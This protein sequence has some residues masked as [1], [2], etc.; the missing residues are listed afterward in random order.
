MNIIIFCAVAYGIYKLIS[1]FAHR[2]E[3]I[4]AEQAAQHEA[5]R[6][7]DRMIIDQARKA[8]EHDR[9]IAVLAKEQQKQAEQIARIQYQLNTATA[10]ID[11]LQSHIAELD[12]QLDYYLLQQSGAVPGSKS[13]ETYQNKIVSLHSKI[14]TAE[15]NLIKARYQQAQAQRKL[16]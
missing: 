16:A 10:N 1:A 7:R 8:A 13:F 5:D 6:R 11:Y 9:T 15:N 4:E 14:H 2:M 12:A 3:R